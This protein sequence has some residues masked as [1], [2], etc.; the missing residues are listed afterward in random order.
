MA[1]KPTVDIIIVN[2]NAG[3]YLTN[4]L[5]SLKS[6][7]KTN[8]KLN[9]IIVD[10]ASIDDSIRSIQPSRYPWLTIVKNPKNVG[11]AAGCNIGIRRAKGSFVLLLNPDTKVSKDT[12]VK[13]VDFL[14]IHPKAGIVT[15]KIV[16]GDGSVDPASHRGFPTPWASFTYF[17]GLEKLFPKKA[18]F[19]QY[20]LSYKSMDKVHEI[21]STSGAF[22]LIKKEVINKIGLLDEDFFMY[23]EDIDFCYRAKKHGFQIF[24]NPS[25][26]VVHAKGISSGIKK[27]SEKKSKATTETRLRTS[28]HFYN[29]MKIFYRKHYSAKYPKIL[30]TLIFLFIDIK[31]TIKIFQ[32]KYL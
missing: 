10:N 11:F 27:H 14:K 18:K 4:C 9:C 17:V 29:T 8:F 25:S 20:H 19:S 30:E 13:M 23:A 1:V 16:L 15:A 5:N 7:L 3:I 26:V 22:M 24:Y 12:I 31:K 28:G 21:D 32:L 2:Y 6:C